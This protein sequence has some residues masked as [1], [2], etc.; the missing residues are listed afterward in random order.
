MDENA[1]LTCSKCGG[2]ISVDDPSAK[3]IEEEGVLVVHYSPAHTRV[4]LINAESGSR[5]TVDVS[6]GKAAT[7][8]A[9]RQI[10][11]VIGPY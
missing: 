8:P 4:V 3:C 2:Q 11:G 10:G 1:S 5:H 7:K 9:S 6:E